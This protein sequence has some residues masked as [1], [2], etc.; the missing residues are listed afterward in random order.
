[1]WALF[2]SRT[3]LGVARW[4]RAAPA[5]YTMVSAT[6]AVGGLIVLDIK[7]EEK[8]KEVILIGLLG[9]MLLSE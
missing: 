2:L 1:M 9:P 5:S 3:T 6:S 8:S 4:S 7:E